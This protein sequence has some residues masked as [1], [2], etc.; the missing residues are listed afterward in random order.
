MMTRIK[1]LFF[2]ISGQARAQYLVLLMLMLV[3]SLME[4]VGVGAIPV[5]IYVLSHPDVI[6]QHPWANP[7]VAWL[8]VQQARQMMIG[9]FVLLA[10]LFTIKNAFYGFLVFVKNRIIY[11]DQ[12]RLGDRLF[13]AYLKADYPFFLNRNSAELLRNV[14]HETRLVISGVI[15]PLMEVIMD[16]LVLLMIVALL[17]KVE[18]F[19][20]LATF[21]V[22]GTLS[23]IFMIITNRK[24]KSYG[25]EAQYHRRQMNKI[26][27]E[28]ISGIKE[29]K[30]LGRE[31]HFL[32]Q[33]H[34]SAVR[35]AVSLRYKQI[36]S[37]LPKPFM[38]IIAVAGMIFISLILLMMNR[39]I[40]SFIPVL[41][42]FGTASLRLLPVFRTMVSAYTDIRY[43][44]YAV[45]PIFD[46]L[47]LLE[48]GAGKPFETKKMPAF[49]PYPFT[50]EIVFRNVSYRYPQ[51]KEEAI[52]EI[53]LT[54]PKG[55]IIGL[56]GPSGSGKTTVVDILL[57]LLVPQRGEVLVDHQNIFQ[58]VRRWRMNVGYVPQ[59]IHLS[60]DNIR[61]NIA[62]GVPDHEID[63]RKIEQAMKAAQ[64]EQLIRMLPDGLDTI[65]RERG[66]RLSGGQRQRIGIARA[67]YHNPQ[68][69]IMD[70]ATSALDSV[71]ER[72]VI[73]ALES[74]RGDRT[75][76]MIAHRLTTVQNCD[77]IYLIH[78]GRIVDHGR[79]EDLVRSSKIFRQMNLME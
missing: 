44:I 76:V 16:G 29:V 52:R 37:Q 42:L 40:D 67:L 43:N 39:K 51:G 55:A 59:Y 32:S 57:G 13:R 71:T 41:A 74:L 66:V 48:V 14:N 21:L 11:H 65:I 77:E 27:L 20:S 58:D 73:E 15:V 79:H 56:V 24:N 28:G 25:R 6:S 69:L 17:V 49:E 3:N 68:V 38:E 23:F 5:F 64:L 12:V 70:E 54:I 31:D 50:S 26:V 46:D 53:D 8:P 47:T 60:D 7:F 10:V 61:K 30:V 72:S 35:T 18:P 4:M 34:L 78:E 45:D 75:I 9:V 2:L 1:K 22:L 19:I 36:I 62:L 63:E 33:Y